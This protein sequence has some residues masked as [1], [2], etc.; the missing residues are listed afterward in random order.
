MSWYQQP[1]WTGSI[2][3]LDVYFN[4]LNGHGFICGNDQTARQTKD[5]GATWIDLAPVLQASG[6]DI[7]AI[8]LNPAANKLYIGADYA[9]IQ[10]WDNSP[11]G[12]TPMSLPFALNQNYPN[13]FNPSTTIS[14]TIDRDGFVSLNVYDVAGRTVGTIL[15]KHMTAGTYEVGFNASGLASGV[16]FYKLRTNEQEMTR[17]MILLR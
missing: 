3:L 16:Y 12:D 2:E 1:S 6:D 15:N 11:T 10:Y 7:N 13:P 17:K 9:Q 4:P 8:Y 5:G 14:F